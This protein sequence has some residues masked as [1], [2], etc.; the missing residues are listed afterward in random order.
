MAINTPYVVYT[1]SDTV[2]HSNDADD[3]KNDTTYVLSKAIVNKLYISEKVR[4][5]FEYFRRSAVSSQHAHI[6][7]NGSPVS[8]A[9]EHFIEGSEGW[10]SYHYDVDIVYGDSI[11]LY[12]KTDQV[13]TCLMR[14]FRILGT[15]EI[16]SFDNSVV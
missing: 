9:E 1:L 15:C 8:G 11:E 10:L 14:H 7:L 2:I 3:E 13:N 16:A 6:Y 5:Y 12:I 4:V